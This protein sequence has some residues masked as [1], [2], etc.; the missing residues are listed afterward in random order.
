[1]QS[2]E[3]S[4]KSALWPWAALCIVKIKYVRIIIIRGH[5]N[6]MLPL[7]VAGNKRT[8]HFSSP[9]EPPRP[10][11]FG[12]H[13]LLWYFFTRLTLECDLNYMGPLIFDRFHSKYL[14]CYLICICWIHGCGT[15]DMGVGGGTE[16]C[17][18]EKFQTCKGLVPHQC[19]HCSRSNFTFITGV[20]ISEQ[21]QMAK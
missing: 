12:V 19:T 13:C 1:M 11:V 3:G 7:T 8:L 15:T 2:P 9:S 18:T 21:Y 16:V 10:P 4:A 20:C 5:R 17:V 14:Q 6:D